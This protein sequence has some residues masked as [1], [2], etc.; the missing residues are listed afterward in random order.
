MARRLCLDNCILYIFIHA[1]TNSPWAEIIG[2][3]VLDFEFRGTAV[4]RAVESLA[5]V[6][7]RG[8]SFCSLVGERSV[9]APYLPAFFLLFLSSLQ[10]RQNFLHS[11]ATSPVSL[12]CVLRNLHSS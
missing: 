3:P 10:K 7:H 9:A 8:A 6:R 2:S 5:L 12:V 1:I 11:S 4:L